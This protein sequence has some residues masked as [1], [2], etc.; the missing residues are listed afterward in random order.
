MP[1]LKRIL[2]ATDFSPAGQRAVMR[3]GQLAQ[4]WDA[5]LFLTHVRPDWN[6]FSRWRPAVPDSYQDVA[7]CSDV[8]MRSTLAELES[9]F[10]IHTRCDSRLGKA[11]GVITALVNELEPHLV[12]IGA[13]GEHEGTTPAPWLGG[14]AL[15]LLGRFQAPLLLVRREADTAYSSSLVAVDVE[16]PLARRAVLW[17]SGLIRAG[18]CHIVHV[19]DVPYIERMRL[20]GIEQSVLERRIRLSEESAGS[21]ARELAR[22]AEGEAKLHPRAVRGE[23]VTAILAEIA[24]V[25]PDIVIVGQRG[26]EALGDLRSPIGGVGFRIAYHAP[27]DVLVLA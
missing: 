8:P 5:N 4:Q 6:L 25:S 18:D 19:Y 11:S 1:V 9:R 14:T 15:K 13:R 22:A 23:P 2:V 17:G 12:V 27:T 26:P 20:A 3:A 7:R 21:I 10:R 24:R 16:S